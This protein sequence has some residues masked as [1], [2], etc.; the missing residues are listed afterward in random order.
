MED[1]SSFSVTGETYRF[2]AR[3]PGAFLRRAASAIFALA[4]TIYLAWRQPLADPALARAALAGAAALTVL[5]AAHF[6]VGWHR[7]VLR[8]EIQRASGIPRLR[9]SLVYL[10]VAAV[11]FALIALP[12]LCALIAVALLGPNAAPP[13]GALALIVALALIGKLALALPAAAVGKRR[14][15]RQGWSLSGGLAPQLLLVLLLTAPSLVAAVAL[16]V[17][18]PQLIGPGREGAGAAW[19]WPTAG[20]A[21]AI[22]V[23]AMLSAAIGATALSYAYRWRLRIDNTHWWRHH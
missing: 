17:F 6:A 5:I 3:S 21:L 23:L 15:L 4:G 19:D 12:P 22:A 16:A 2:L 7:Y 10:A 14:P 9:L 1:F 11:M 13:I 8:P 20:M 18:G